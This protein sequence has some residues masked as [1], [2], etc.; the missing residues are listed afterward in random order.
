MS[1]SYFYATQV[2]ARP[3]SDDREWGLYFTKNSLTEDEARARYGRDPAIVRTDS[4]ASSA[5]QMVK[6]ARA[7]TC[8]SGRVRTAWNS[9]S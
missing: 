2:S 5:W 3:E 9:R 8:A 7:P 6:I 4:S 1:P